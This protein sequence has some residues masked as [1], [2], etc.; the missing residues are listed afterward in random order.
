ME[1]SANTKLMS[2]ILLITIPTIA[3]GG[4]FLLRV[5]AGR[6]PVPLTDFQKSMFRAGHA[7]AGVLVLLA[8]IAQVLVDT[9]AFSIGSE[10]LIRSGFGAAPLFISGGFFAAAGHKNATRPNKSIVLIWIGAAVLS[11]VLLVL[12]IRLIQC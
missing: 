10:W 4:T 11:A 1:L 9:A 2:G 6:S 12:G 3:Y 5:L 8:L 7:H